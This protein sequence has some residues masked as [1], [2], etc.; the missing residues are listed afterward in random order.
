[1]LLLWQTFGCNSFEFHHIPEIP[2]SYDNWVS[3]H[4]QDQT[5]SASLKYK[6]SPGHNVG[7]VLVAIGPFYV[8]YNRKSVFNKKK[9]I[10]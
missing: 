1:M 2:V 5:C 6:V 3:T 8:F 9:K 7:K 10:K 4:L